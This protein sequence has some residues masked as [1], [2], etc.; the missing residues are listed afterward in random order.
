M[1]QRTVALA[2]VIRNLSHQLHPGVLQHGG[3]VAALKGHCNE[4]SRQHGIEVT[5]SMPEG[6]NGVPTDIALCLYRVAQEALQNI[7]QHARAHEVKVTLKSSA[8]EIELAIAD[9]GKGF[10]FD[11]ARS[12]G[13]LGLISLD[14]R[15]R[16]LGG[17]L[18][19]NSELQHGT[20]LRALV[21]LRRN[22]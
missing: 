13:G 11:N 10:L 1:Q 20:E 3:L 7:A 15:V 19:I 21:P 16:L 4:F 8:D 2:D 18:E 12:A 9:D 5:L 17:G 14:E 6:I 22:P